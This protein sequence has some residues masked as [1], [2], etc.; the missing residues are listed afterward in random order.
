MRNKTENTGLE[1]EVDRQGLG[2]VLMQTPLACFAGDNLYA[3][4]TQRT[5]SLR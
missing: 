2:S 1:N 5:E 3:Q 4:K